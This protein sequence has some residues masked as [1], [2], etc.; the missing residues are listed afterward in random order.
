MAARAPA[1]R[2]VAPAPAKTVAVAPAVVEKPA[3]S[4]PA[5]RTTRKKP[6]RVSSPQPAV[7]PARSAPREVRSAVRV[8]A[9]PEVETI[10]RRRFALAGAALALV[11]IGGGVLLGVGG[12]TL[13]EG[14][15]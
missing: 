15:A 14:L 3:V 2:A 1:T 6:K 12:R 4:K 13:K 7:P 9:G 8:I 11:A 10:Q 5:A